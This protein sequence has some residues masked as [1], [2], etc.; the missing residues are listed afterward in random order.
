MPGTRSDASLPLID[1][2]LLWIA[3]FQRLRGARRQRFHQGEVVMREGERPEVVA[4]V[5]HG[6][7]LVSSRTSCGR[8]AGLS[9]LGPA[10][11]IG[12]QA[13]ASDPRPETVP[14][15]LSLVTSTLLTVP[16]TS[17]ETVLPRDMLLLRG[18]AAA[19]TEQLDR[20]QTALARALSLPVVDRVRHALCDLAGRFGTRVPGGTKIM[21]PVSQ[22]FLASIAGATRESV[23]RAL[24]ELRG[25]RAVR[26][27]DGWYVW[28][29]KGPDQE[30]PAEAIVSQGRLPGLS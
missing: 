29:E 12:H 25:A 10:D 17:V 15:A 1:P 21:L 16:A 26:M 28:M 14:G 8:V 13:L 20:T 7:V 22:D 18:F 6:A 23:N 19:V 4:V 11:V 30:R 5:T 27:E 24:R 3:R 2:H 9:V